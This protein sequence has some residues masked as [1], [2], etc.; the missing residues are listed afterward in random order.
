MRHSITIGIVQAAP[1]YLD[2]EKSLEKA[3]K[4]IEKAIKKGAEL[5]VFG[6]TWFTGYPAWIDHCPD[7]ARWNHGPVKKVYARMLA[8]SIR[9]PGKELAH[10]QKLAATHKVVIVLGANETTDSGIG[11]G[12]IYNS[13]LI[14][15]ADGQLAN[16]HRK[17]VPTF[18]ERLLYGIGDAHGLKAVQTGLGRIGGL[19]CWEHWMPLA[20]Q[21]MH[22]S[23]EHIHVALWPTVHE[24]HQ[25]ASRHYAFEGRC[26]V[27]AVG[28][29]MHVKDIPEDLELPAELKDKPDH[30]TL[31]GGSCIIGPDATFCLEPQFN[32]EGIIIHTLE[33][34]NRVLEEKI[35]L[36]TSGHYN[37]TD[38]F[39]FQIDTRRRGS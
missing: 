21:A 22:N 27:V 8:N 25:L 3:L 2:A 19:I 35:T 31:C 38:L 24:V 16:H 20:R 37:R 28:Q 26:Y 1:V 17:L 4:L 14:I 30:P 39:D 18:N 32:T 29:I 9:V 23:G 6:E 11:N 10:L 5:V 34:M 36:D 33:N 15:N 12:T 13:L 7:V